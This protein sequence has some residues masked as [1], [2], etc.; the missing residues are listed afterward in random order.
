MVSNNRDNN[1]FRY[2]HL[3]PA[4]AAGTEPRSNPRATATTPSSRPPPPAPV[5]AAS[6][7]PDALV[8][9]KREL[10]SLNH[11]SDLAL[12]QTRDRSGGWPSFVLT[13]AAAARLSPET[14]AVL[15]ELGVPAATSSY[16]QIIDALDLA[17][18]LVE[19]LPRPR[20]GQPAPGPEPEPAYLKA[21]GVAD[22]LLVK[23]QIKRYE[24]GEIAHIE[25]LLAGESKTRTHRQLDRTEEVFI[26]VKE[27]QHEKETELQTTE[28]FELNRETAKTFEIDQKFGFGLTLSGKYGPTVEFSSNLNLSEESHETEAQ[29][30]AVTY[31]K[32]IVE[33]SKERIV[34][35]MRTERRLTLLREIEETNEHRLENTSAVHS[36]GIFQF[37][38]KIYELQVFNYGLRQMFDF[39]IPEPSSYLWYL[40]RLPRPDVDLPI[41]PIRLELEA[42]NATFI[43][44][45][46]YLRLGARY[47]AKSLKA[48]PPSLLTKSATVAQGQ[49]AESEEDQPRSRNEMEIS[50]PDGFRPLW[51]FLTVMGMTDEQPTLAFS[52]GQQN[53]VWKPLPADRVKLD[54]PSSPPLELF[55]SD[56]IIQVFDPDGATTIGEEKLKIH[57]FAYETANY[58][59]HAK[60]QFQSEPEALTA[61][62]VATYDAIAEA[63]NNMLLQ[64]QQDVEALK[65]RAKTQKD[66]EFEF[67]NPP[68]VNER[69]VRTE[70]RKHCLAIIRNEHLGGLNTVHTPGSGDIPPQFDLVDARM[71]GTE[72]RFFEH[73]FEWDQM[74]YVF[75]PYFWARPG[76]WADRFHARNMDPA[77]E[78]FLKAGY[79]RVVV[80]VRPGFEPAV[81]Y[82]LEKRKVWEEQGEP[83]IND[84]LYKSIVDEIKERVGGIHTEVP[85]DEPWETRL[86]TAAILVRKDE[87]LPQWQRLSPDEWDWK[88]I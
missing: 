56:T 67:G 53:R 65:Q 52:I 35:T 48:P 59:V 26:S 3:R 21:V 83:T 80:P 20:P 29:K 16:T 58:S 10:T 68:S 4:K 88:P 82:Y 23:Q 33:R 19:R 9:A 36:A 13:A 27:Q 2:I 86:P 25:N 66:Y 85:V 6:A 47:S 64:Y 31:A 69:I 7:R 72:I 44:E 40:E 62:Q 61:W 39:M 84:P 24:A 37:V 49:G 12:S 5:E 34:E 77:L 42:P 70:L 8:R 18:S 41:P 51:C 46:N 57:V 54:D 78:E 11:A 1:V 28:R 30:N 60:V 79:A 43:N 55:Q 45:G 73:A 74:Q 32:E 38:D 22:L 75:Y 87:T 17:L 63:Y 81:S 14:Q 71:D 76:G 15:R 50:I